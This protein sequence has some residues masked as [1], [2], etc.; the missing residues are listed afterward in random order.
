MASRGAAE[1]GEFFKMQMKNENTSSGIP[2][3][4]NWPGARARK[5]GEGVCQ[6]TSPWNE[7]AGRAAGLVLHI[8]TFA[9]KVY[10]AGFFEK[11]RAIGVDARAKSSPWRKFVLLVR[12]AVVDA[13]RLLLRN[14]LQTPVVPLKACK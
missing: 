3:W 14:R 4:R 10:L 9:S 2:R 7:E 1:R 8:T 12:T 6:R 13:P 5:A 11:K